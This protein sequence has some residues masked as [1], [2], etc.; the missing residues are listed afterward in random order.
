MSG[1]NARWW[2]SWSLRSRIQIGHGVDRIGYIPKVI[3]RWHPSRRRV[4]SHLLSNRH[5][6]GP[7]LLGR[8]FEVRYGDH[9]W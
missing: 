6:G 9:K 5:G 7:K 3:G 1:R 4:R 2:V 8:H